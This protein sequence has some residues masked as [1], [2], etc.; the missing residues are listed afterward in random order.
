MLSAP[1]ELITQLEKFFEI[2]MTTPVQANTG[3]YE[4][5]FPFKTDDGSFIYTTMIFDFGEL[6]NKSVKLNEGQ[7]LS[8][9]L[10]FSNV[11]PCQN[12]GYL[13]TRILPENLEQKGL[14]EIVIPFCNY[15]DY[16][17]GYVVTGIT[18]N[19]NDYSRRTTNCSK[20]VRINPQQEDYDA[21]TCEVPLFTSC[22]GAFHLST[23]TGFEDIKN[24]TENNGWLFS[25]DGYCFLEPENVF[26]ESIYF[27]DDLNNPAIIIN[28]INRYGS[29]NPDLI[30][31]L[32]GSQEEIISVCEQSLNMAE[33]E[34]I[35]I[36]CEL[37]KQDYPYSFWG[38]SGNI[39]A[40]IIS[41]E[42]QDDNTHIL[43]EEPVFE[44]INVRIVPNSL[45]AQRDESEHYAKF[46]FQ[47][48]NNGDFTKKVSYELWGKRIDDLTDPTPEDYLVCSGEEEIIQGTI[49][50]I[51]CKLNI[52]QMTIIDCDLSEPRDGCEYDGSTTLW[53][54]IQ[55]EHQ[56]AQIFKAQEIIQ[57][58]HNSFIIPIYEEV[59]VQEFATPEII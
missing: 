30:I 31:K 28:L 53:A 6:L 3:E 50:T 46:S 54:T 21:F 15:G 19:Y 59:G 39:N 7:K 58:N 13:I 22:E 23:S 29:R 18:T 34:E 26:F 51:Q 55:V 45:T 49:K 33:N 40:I 11:R 48:E 24:A 14:A 37:K 2:T 20:D 25:R 35:T 9:L 5:I 4:I 10:Y 1:F 44:Y 41:D 16:E 32:T 8:D 52:P 12:T 57:T 17:E 43:N 47:I 38:S 42:Y 56:D 36:T 27:N